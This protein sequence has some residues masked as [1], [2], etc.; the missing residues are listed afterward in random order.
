MEIQ[1]F[2][3]TLVTTPRTRGTG[4]PAASERRNTSASCGHTFLPDFLTI[5]PGWRVTSR[6]NSLCRGTC[7]QGGSKANIIAQLL[8]DDV[9]LN[10]Q[11]IDSIQ[12]VPGVTVGHFMD[13]IEGAGR[14]HNEFGPL[15]RGCRKRATDQIALLETRLITEADRAMDAVPKEF[16]AGQATRQYPT[17]NGAYY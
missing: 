6:A 4:S 17:A 13:A 3:S 10:A 16:I 2:P 1:L 12:A 15:R 8:D 14:D 9:S 11:H 7:I 5:S